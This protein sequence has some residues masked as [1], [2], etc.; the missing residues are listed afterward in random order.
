MAPV[1]EAASKN[2][3]EKL[4]ALLEADPDLVDEEDDEYEED[5]DWDGRR[6]TPLA[7]ACEAGALE[8]ARLLIE[9]GANI[10]E[11]FNG[12]YTPLMIAC[13]RGHAGVVSLLLDQGAD[14]TL[15]RDF[16]G[17]DILMETAGEGTGPGSIFGM[18]GSDFPAVLRLLIEDGRVPVDLRDS[19]RWTALYHA[20]HNGYSDRARVLLLEGRADH[21][22]RSRSGVTPKVAAQRRVHEDCVRLLEVNGHSTY[23]HSM[24]SPI[25][26]DHRPI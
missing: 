20:C 23:C 10:E 19:C 13:L 6:W 16:S 3:V 18:P 25:Q 22:I 12:V 7:Y 1:H 11:V 24:C 15:H 2:D 14:P 17:P 4:R 21:T 9:E 26:S 5:E 8:A